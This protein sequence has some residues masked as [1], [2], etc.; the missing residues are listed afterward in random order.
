LGFTTISA[1]SYHHWCRKNEKT[2]NATNAALVAID[3]KTGQVL[4]LIGSKD[5]GEDQF[6]VAT[7]PNRQPGSSFKPFAYAAAFSKGY[8]PETIL[9]DLETSFGEFGPVGE[10]KSISQIIMI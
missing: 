10:E 4:A 2:Y 5:Y 8:S 7:S 6:N 3:P 1:R 9:F